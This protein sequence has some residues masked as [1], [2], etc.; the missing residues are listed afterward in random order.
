MIKI[1]GEHERLSVLKKQLRFAFNGL[2][3]GVF[4]G[5]VLA[6]I[7][8]YLWYVRVQRPFDKARKEKS[9]SNGT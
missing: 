4:F 7:G 2:K 6:H 8:F 1:E 5:Y 3:F 9:E